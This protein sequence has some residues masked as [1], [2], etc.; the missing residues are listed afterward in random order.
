MEQPNVPAALVKASHG[1]PAFDLNRMSFFV[2]RETIVPRLPPGMALWREMLFK[3]MLRNAASA[4]EFFQIP[5]ERVVEL[6]T[7]IEI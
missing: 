3:L 6:G 1:D 4:A 5:A 7:Q 2:S